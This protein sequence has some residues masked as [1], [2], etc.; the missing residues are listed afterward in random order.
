MVTDVE[1]C[2]VQ[3]MRKDPWVSYKNWVAM[4]NW[5]EHMDKIAMAVQ[6]GMIDMATAAKLIQEYNERVQN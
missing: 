2:I 1:R 4:K 5:T 6:Q 3:E